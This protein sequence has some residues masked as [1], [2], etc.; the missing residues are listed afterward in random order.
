MGGVASRWN[1]H[2]LVKVNIFL[3]LFWLQRIPIRTILVG[4]GVDLDSIICSIF[5]ADSEDVVH[6]FFQCD[7]ARLIWKRVELWL[8]LSIPTFLER[9]DFLA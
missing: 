1:N 7:L 6:L 4:R 8:D 9:T 3:W 5:H 2:I